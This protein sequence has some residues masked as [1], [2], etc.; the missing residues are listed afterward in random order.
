MMRV[1]KNKNEK[2][3]VA[4][5]TAIVFS[6]ILMTIAISLNQIGFLTRGETADAEYKDRSTALAEGCAD[7]ALLKLANDITYAGN[8]SGIAIG[9]DVCSIGSVGPDP[10]DAANK[11]INTSAVYPA[12]TNGAVTRLQIKININS[13]SVVSW[14]EVP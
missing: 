10:L 12:G 9:S 5:I 14:N 3:F 11:I 7:V 2:G 4:L 6:A 1:R 8:E 13:L